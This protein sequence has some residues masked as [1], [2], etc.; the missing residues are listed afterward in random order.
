[1]DRVNF[2]GVPL[3]TFEQPFFDDGATAIGEWIGL[4]NWHGSADARVGEGFVFLPETRAVFGRMTRPEQTSV[5]V[6][7]V[8]RP[9]YDHALRLKGEVVGLRSTFRIDVPVGAAGAEVPVPADARRLSL[10]LIASDNTVLDVHSESEAGVAGQARA[11][12]S[13][14]TEEDVLGL[15]E[16]IDGGENDHTEFKSYVDPQDKKKFEEVV[17]T[18][19]AFANAQG[20]RLLLGVSDYGEVL[21]VDGDL[22]QAPE[23][24]RDGSDAVVAYMRAIDGR[25][26]QLVAPTPAFTIDA[27]RVKGQTVVVIDVEEHGAK[28]CERADTHGMFVRRGATNRVITRADVLSLPTDKRAEPGSSPWL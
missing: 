23:K 2:G 6:D 16:V 18:V 11:L 20:G 26:R 17:R 24:A 28:P 9:G 19:I 14:D 25:L 7:V 4:R 3:V 1:M 5:H 21:G 22:V 13:G 15:G 8:R 27:Q 12:S 10:L